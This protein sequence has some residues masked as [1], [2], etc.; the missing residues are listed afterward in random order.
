[1]KALL[2]GALWVHLAASVGLVGAFFMLLLAGP[3]RGA[4]ARRWDRDIVGFTRVLVLVALVSGGVWL[5]LRTALFENRPAAALEARAVWHA[6]L[7]TWPGLVWLARHSLLVLLAAFLAIPADVGARSEWIAARGQALGL[8][9]LALLLTSASSH[10]AAVTPG[11]G[12]AVVSDVTHLLG[13]GLWAGGL[14][15]LGLL[16]RVAGRETGA[17][18]LPYAVVAT[19]RFSSVALIVMLALIASGVGSAIVQVESIAG[20]AGTTH[21]RLLLAKLAVLVPVLVIAGVNRT[22]VLPSLTTRPVMRRL[23]VFV[24]LEAGL[25]LVML[26]LAAAMT[27]TTP[28][29]HG[30]AV[31]PLPFRISLEALLDG[32]AARRRVFL[33]TQLVVLGVVVLIAAL[34]AGRRRAPALAGALALVLVGAGVGVSP[35]VVDAYPTTYRRPAV[36]YHVASIASGMAVYRDHCA[37][38]HGPGGADLRGAR[39]SRRHAGELFWLVTHGVAPGMPPFAERLTEPQRWDVINFIRALAAADG[40]T[41]LGPDV[42]LDDAW[43]IPP[44]FTIA[45]GPLAPGAL[46]D[47]R[48]RRMVLVVLYT[49]PG[50]RARLSEL[51]RSYDLLSVLGVEIIAVP[52]HAPADALGELGG[53]SPPVLFPV[54]TD[55][56]ADIVATYRL[57]APGPHT[58]LLVDRQ[59]YIRAIWR[60]APGSLQAQVE[61]LNAEKDVPPFADDHV[62]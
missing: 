13:T 59:G 48:G 43:L 54:V 2:L 26:A 28:A 45:V 53:A 50:S 46:R 52:T 7:D 22:R 29:R 56:A 38:C 14:V 31:W 15:A 58:E 62:H 16:L 6:V 27:L 41:R 57:F 36:T 34:V 11:T 47:H 55:G 39:T 44:D 42:Q 19:R 49:L 32:A 21:G 4:T 9:T 51:A 33:G 35:L 30:E 20:L 18:A 10:A 8:A 3:A 23:A 40:S 1:M 61:K 60:D 12:W 24:V 17:D 5:L 37:E 25:A